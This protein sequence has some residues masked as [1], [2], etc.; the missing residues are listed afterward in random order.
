MFLLLIIIAIM[1]ILIIIKDFKNQFYKYTVI[2]NQSINEIIRSSSIINRN[3]TN[4]ENIIKDLKVNKSSSKKNNKLNENTYSLFQKDIDRL[5]PNKRVLI[6][7]R[8]QMSLLTK[9]ELLKV[10]INSEIFNSGEELISVI[11]SF[12]NKYDAI[13]IGSIIDGDYSSK[14]I[15]KIL[16]N[17]EK[18]DKPIFIL[19][20][21]V[22]YLN[23]YSKYGFDGYIKK[24]LSISEMIDAFNNINK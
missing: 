14:E 21:D 8:T 12:K 15:V 10:N 1:H 7:D 18:V 9:S 13:F 6:L 24:P 23:S 3:F 11:S 22:T 20:T 4:V 2:L 5:F 16:H 19:T 17:N